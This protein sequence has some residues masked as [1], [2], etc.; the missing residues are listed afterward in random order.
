M[1]L[2]LASFVLYVLLWSLMW[3]V[4]L[5]DHFAPFSRVPLSLPP[6]ISAALLT[7]AV[8]SFHVAISIGLIELSHIQGNTLASRRC[9]LAASNVLPQ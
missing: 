3:F 7:L 1:R 8:N 6:A 5:E 9:S 4:E 2:P